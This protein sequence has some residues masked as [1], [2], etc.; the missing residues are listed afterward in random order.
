MRRRRGIDDRMTWDAYHDLRD[1]YTDLDDMKTAK[2]RYERLRTDAEESIPYIRDVLLE[3]LRRKTAHADYNKSLHPNWKTSVYTGYGTYGYANERSIDLIDDYETRIVVNQRRVRENTELLDEVTEKIRRKEMEIAAFNYFEDRFLPSFRTGQAG[4]IVLGDEF[5]RIDITYFMARLYKYMSTVYADHVRRG[6]IEIAVF[7][8][9]WTVGGSRSRYSKRMSPEYLHAFVRQ[10]RPQLLEG[11]PGVGTEIEVKSDEV[12]D[13][14]ESRE[15]PEHMVA[16]LEGRFDYVPDNTVNMRRL[17]DF[18]PYKNRSKLDL[19]RYQIY[20]DEEAAIRGR[21]HCLLWSLALAYMK[22]C[23]DAGYKYALRCVTYGSM[24]EYC[25]EGK[26]PTNKLSVYA[27]AIKCN[28]K[29][30]TFREDGRVRSTDYPRSKPHPITLS[31]CH[32]MDHYMVYDVLSNEYGSSLRFL[33]AYE[34]NFVPLTNMA[35]EARGVSLSSYTEREQTAIDKEYWGCEIEEPLEEAKVVYNK[36]VSAKIKTKIYERVLK[37]RALTWSYMLKNTDISFCEMNKL[38][39]KKEKV[40]EQV[41]GGNKYRYS[42]VDELNKLSCPSQVYFYDFETSVV[43]KE[44]DERCLEIHKQLELTDTKELRDEYERLNKQRLHKPYLVCSLCYYKDKYELKYFTTAKEFLSY[45]YNN[46]ERDEN[47]PRKPKTD[48]EKRWCKMNN[49][50]KYLPFKQVTLIA[51]NQNYDIKYLL[52]HL[53]KVNYFGTSSNAKGFT[54]S[55]Y[56]LRLKCIDSYRIFTT[57]LR[58][59]PKM[60]GLPSV[61]E[62]FPYTFFTKEVVENMGEYPISEVLEHIKEGDRATFLSQVGPLIE[63]DGKIDVKAMSIKYCSTDV[64]L[65]AV[66][67]LKFRDS[68]LLQMEL[69][70]LNYYTSASIADAVYKKYAV[71]NGVY[72]LVGYC[73]TFIEKTVRGGRVLSYM[74]KK[75][76]VKGKRMTNVDACSLYPTAMLM[77][78]RELGGLPCGK[79]K[80]I[81]EDQLNYDFLSQ[82]KHY[83]VKVHVKRYGRETQ[84][85]ILCDEIGGSLKYYF[86]LPEGGVTTHLNS[87]AL[88]DL[89]KYNEVDPVADIEYI[90]GYYFDGETNDCIGSLMIYLYEL[91]KMYK[92]AGNPIQEVYKL[93]LNSGYGKTLMKRYD[94]E[95]SLITFKDEN[96]K[97][98]QL[99]KH[100]HTLKS[101]TEINEKQLVIDTAKTGVHSNRAHIG[102]LIL[103]MSKRIMY[104]LSDILE[105]QGEKIYYTDT[106]SVYIEEAALPALEKTWKELYGY[107]FQGNDMGQFHSDITAPAGASD[108]Y[109]SD[110]TCIGPKMKSSTIQYDLDGEHKTGI[111]YTCKGIT[112]GCFVQEAKERETD[113]HAIYDLIYDGNTVTFDLAKVGCSFE[114]TPCGT[115]SRAVFNRKVSCTYA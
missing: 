68:L 98:E 93:L 9:V 36:T 74:Q 35:Y 18:F 1:L 65:L 38:I 115:F 99:G 48:N 17:G 4:D 21:K 97:Y 71:Y 37:Y 51:H 52:P 80:R 6:G 77:L 53:H 11:L 61:K 12:Y 20:N 96:D 46:K 42:L 92:K 14:A 109:I 111:N 90:E 85:P 50:D 27:D 66:C 70:A 103:A 40:L 113:I 110:F 57:A 63:D 41:R 64:L 33:R 67:Y 95:S 59:M 22:E 112:K 30:Y 101:Y 86:T 2:A 58:N 13:E 32:W 105:R 7:L 83:F 8:K 84:F 81:Q 47:R 106:D 100:I 78:A 34:S 60:F 39:E 94:T 104:R 15:D 82:Y 114:S 108:V 19:S 89:V 31:I 79:P 43:N 72:D 28:I 5:D 45:V 26:Y 10:L 3:P 88:E 16:H 56:D 62:V 49:T 75:I 24:M 107:D 55:Y 102:S 76:R 44:L 54:A 23:P 73:R 25:R 87:I 69:D 91:R 29:L